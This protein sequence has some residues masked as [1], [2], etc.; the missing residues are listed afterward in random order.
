MG[1]EGLRGEGL[2]FGLSYILQKKS[3]K[4]QIFYALYFL[5]WNFQ[6]NPKQPLT[7]H[8]LI[9]QFIISIKK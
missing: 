4:H 1:V 9:H 6:F 5:F 7:P 8:P 2:F 3:I